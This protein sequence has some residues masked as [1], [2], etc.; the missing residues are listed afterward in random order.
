[1]SR[2]FGSDQAG[3]VI[4]VLQP[5]A[6]SAPRR[7]RRRRRWPWVVLVVVLVLGA[8]AAAAVRVMTIKPPNVVLRVDF[9]TSVRPRAA[10]LRPGWPSTG[11]A[12]LV[13]QGPQLGRSIGSSGGDAPRPIASLAKLMTA[14]LT[15]KDYPL[16]GSSGGFTVT[17]TRAEAKAE[18]K[19]AKQGDSVLVVRAGEQL[20]ERQLLEGLLVPS[21]DNIALLLAAYEAGSVPQFVADMNSTAQ[22]LGLHNTTYTDPSG[23]ASTTVSDATDQLHMLEAVMRFPVFRQIVSMPNVDLPVAGTVS[24][25]DPLISKGY[26]GKTGSDGAAEGCL[27]F[28]KHVTVGGH[29]LTVIGVVLGQGQGQ[30]TSVILGAAAAAAQHLVTSVMRALRVRTV[31]PA[32][33]RVAVISSADGH[34]VQAVTTRPL[35]VVAW[36]GSQEHLTVRTRLLKADSVRAGVRVGRVSL[37]GRL[38]LPRGG[39]RQTAVRTS[40]ALPAPG[41]SWRLGHLLP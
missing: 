5:A 10:A 6:P 3:S 21:G 17:I 23:L 14:Y 26:V 19:Q 13:V 35:K 33:T 7:D 40:T 22:A 11:E 20:D 37:V 36:A 16:T 31:V 30:V 34:H 2:L 41:L 27:A 8:L 12:A 29:P 38:P 4:P 39:H 18:R 15:L 25:Y 28:Y 1:M 24:N 9:A 32:G